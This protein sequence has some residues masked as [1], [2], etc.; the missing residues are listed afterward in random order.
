MC[1]RFVLLKEHYHAILAA[2]GVA[3]RPDFA[4]RYNIAPTTAVPVV[5]TTPRRETAALRWGLVPAWAKADH[6]LNLFNARVE[7]IAE[8]PSFREAL[9]KRRCVIPASGFYEWKTSGRNK[10]PMFVR[11]RDEQPFCFAGLWESWPAPAGAPL[12]SCTLVTTEPNELMRPIHTRMPFMLTPAQ[13]SAWLDATITDAPTAIALLTPLRS[14][15][16]TATAVGDY[17]S[18]VRHEGPECLAPAGES[19]QFSLGL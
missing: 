8:K 13:G 10:Q 4:S 14:D 6:D 9:K 15:E 3:A 18:N 1:N 7:T 17:V 5:R 2:L 11:R 16:M 12:E 19:P